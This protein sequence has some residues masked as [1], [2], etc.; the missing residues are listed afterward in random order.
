MAQNIRDF[1]LLTRDM[2]SPGKSRGELQ[3]FP[4]VD[5]QFSVSRPSG[6]QRTLSMRSMHL[7]MLAEALSNVRELSA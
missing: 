2:T 3:E 5:T 1:R 7:A 4:Y 6:A